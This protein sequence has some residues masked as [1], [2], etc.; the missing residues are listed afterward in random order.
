MEQACPVVTAL[1][2][3]WGLALHPEKT[4]IV[5]R[6]EGFDFLG[7]HVQRRR[8]KLRGTPQQPKG[9]ALRQE[10]RSWLQT[11]PTVTAA[12]VIR[13]LNPLLRGGAMYEHHGVSKHPVQYVDDHIGRGWWR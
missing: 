6:T 5:H 3:E 1:L 7:C 8:A 13:P 10:V 2:Q 9:H 11:H 12:V 4:R